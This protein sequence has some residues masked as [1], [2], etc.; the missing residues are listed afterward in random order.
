MKKCVYFLAP[1]PMHEAPSQRFRFE[2]YLKD[3][4]KLIV[5]KITVLDNHPFPLMDHNPVK[6][7]KQQHVRSNAHARPKPNNGAKPAQS[8]SG[9]NNN[10]KRRFGKPNTA[11]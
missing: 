7:P 11:R 3:I 1:Y 6:V 9:N 2:Q 10:N 8:A 5:K 4:E